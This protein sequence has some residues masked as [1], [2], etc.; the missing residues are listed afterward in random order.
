MDRPEGDH[1]G[2]GFGRESA[3]AVAT[4]AKRVFILADHAKIGLPAASRLLPGWAHRYPDH[5]RARGGQL[6][7]H[8]A[9]VQDCDRRRCLRRSPADQPQP[10]DRTA[11]VRSWRGARPRRIPADSL[12]RAEAR[13]PLALDNRSARGCA[14]VGVRSSIGSICCLCVRAG[15]LIYWSEWQDSNLRPLRPERSALPG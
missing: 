13:K 1:P 3:R 2:C 10:Y 9:Q 4:A 7:A 6:G 11:G 8:S 15:Q 5:R 12:Q 14:P